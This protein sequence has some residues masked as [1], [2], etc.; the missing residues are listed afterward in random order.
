MTKGARSW[1]LGLGLWEHLVALLQLQDAGAGVTIAGT[2]S[3]YIIYWIKFYSAGAM[4]SWLEN[5]TTCPS[6][7]RPTTVGKFLVL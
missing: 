7:V 3:S 4:T 1:S 6:S 5:N 2:A